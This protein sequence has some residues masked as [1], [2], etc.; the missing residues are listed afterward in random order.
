MMNIGLV[1][2]GMVSGYGHLPALKASSDFR[3]TAI[4]DVS[5]QRL[6]QTAAAHPGVTAYS[7]YRDLLKHP[8]LHAIAIATHLESHA[9]ITLAAIDAGLHVLCEKPMASTA[10]ECRAMVDAAK[11]AKRILV[12]NFNS[13]SGGVYPVVKRRIDAGDVGSVRV[14]RIAL[15]WSAHQWQPA[16]RMENF[17]RTGGPVMDSAVHFF[18]AA[19]WFT[20]QDFDRIDANGAFDAKYEHPV[21]AI[22]SCRMTGGAI[23][24]V[25]AGWIYCRNTKD[26]GQVFTLD[27]IGDV[28]AISW[29]AFSNKLRVYKR[30]ATEVIDYSDQDKGFPFVYERFARS[31][32]RGD[33]IDLASGEDGMAATLAAMRALAS[34]KR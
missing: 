15:D 34:T 23:A 8:G 30:D 21:H 25:E 29:D 22:A 33:V 31:I 14:V 32:E 27:V 13:R 6:A 28:G 26:R 11:R 5:A 20:G 9:P 4:A 10:E 7:D 1:G 3:L 24:L 18:E 17:M 12:V 2:L 19:R 16:E